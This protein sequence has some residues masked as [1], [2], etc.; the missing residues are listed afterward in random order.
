MAV[1]NFSWRVTLVNNGLILNLAVLDDF[2]RTND[3]N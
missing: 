1:K 3:F 2:T